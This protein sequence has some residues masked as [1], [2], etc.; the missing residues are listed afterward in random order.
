MENPTQMGG[1]HELTVSR[2][3]DNKKYQSVLRKKLLIKQ[4]K[5]KDDNTYLRRQ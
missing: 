2:L 1:H 5:H 4:H 3:S